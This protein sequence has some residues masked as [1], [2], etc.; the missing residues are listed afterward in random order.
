MG[1]DS[2]E[3]VIKVEETFGIQ[4]P[5]E[6]AAGIQT[7]GQLHDYLVHRMQEM[8]LEVEPRPKSDV[9]LAATAFYRVRRAWLSVLDAE[10]SALRLRLGGLKCC[11]GDYRS[12]P[13]MIEA[14]WPPKPK[15][16]LITA[17]SGRSRGSFGV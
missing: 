9:C 12:L 13:M 7:V 2:V 1:L 3:L 5:D 16:L 17:R 14:L 8:G 4:I 6:D 11:G 10:R 15:L